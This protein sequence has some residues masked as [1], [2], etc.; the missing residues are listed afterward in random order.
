MSSGSHYVV[1]VGW[2]QV[3]ASVTKSAVINVQ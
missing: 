1:I 2:D 3:G